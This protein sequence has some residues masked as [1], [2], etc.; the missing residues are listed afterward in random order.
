M[1]KLTWD[2]VGE[3]T[4]EAGNS[5]AVLYVQDANGTYPEGVAW[6]GWT[7]VSES[8]SGA[9][10][11][12]FYADNIKYGALRGAEEFG[13]SIEAYQSPAE[14]DEC[15]GEAAIAKGVTV[16]QQTRKPFGLCYR[17]E[18]GNDTQGLDYGYIL[19]LV[20]N[21]TASPSEKSYETIN[22]SPEGI[23]MS[24]EFTTT[25]VPVAGHKPTSI[26]RIDSTQVDATKLTAF[27]DILYG[28]D[29]ETNK[30]RLPLP[31]EVI[32]HFNKT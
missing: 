9:D 10:E 13:G 18:I 28:K 7:G 32:S 17:T 8:P 27:E 30:P 4:F 21:A 11:N 24:W 2:G 29:G 6:N 14:F 16:G 5:K 20:Y 25:P 1:P 26:I 19:H 12:A 3:K 15:D 22:E 31:A 23:T